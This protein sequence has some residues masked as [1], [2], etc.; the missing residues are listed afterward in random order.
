MKANAGV[1]KL[2]ECGR[3]RWAKCRHPWYFHFMWK[4]T[5]YRFCLDRHLGQRVAGWKAA[6]DAAEGLRIAIRAGTFEQQQQEQQASVAAPAEPLSVRTL[7]MMFLSGFSQKAAGKGVARRKGALGAKASWRNDRA[8]LN[9]FYSFS[10][11]ESDRHLG[12]MTAA[13]VT[14][15]DVERF[16]DSL[17]AAG[18]AASTRN[19]YL[20]ALKSLSAWGVRKGYLERP[21]IDPLRTEL[22]R[23][24]MAR[25]HRRLAAGEE[26][27]LLAAAP[28]RLQRLIV[29]ALE[30]GCRVGEL[31]GL[32]WHDVSLARREIRLPAAKTKDQDFRVIP[33]SSRFAS[34]LEMAKTDPAGE[35]FGPD[36]FVFGDEIGQRIRSVKKAWATAVLRAHGIKARWSGANQLDAESAAA[37]RAIDL[38]FHDLRHEAGSR[39]LEGGIPIHHCQELLGHADLKTTSIYLNATA[40]GLHESIQ[41]FDETRAQICK[42]FAKKGDRKPRAARAGRKEIASKSLVN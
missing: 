34:V 20:Q 29:A 4:G 12:D 1:R 27:A 5:P 15:G 33:V 6:K 2:C 18:R 9:T 35:D 38:H 22:A 3:P 30:T 25:R 21:W 17:R 37:L 8:M 26:A 31:L 32:Q 11:P 7:G 13:S 23:E 39:W 42:N 19:Q 28:P 36:A 14:E 40:T 10:V 16:L 24:K 41:R